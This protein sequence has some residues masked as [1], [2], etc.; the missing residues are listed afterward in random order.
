M[1]YNVRVAIYL[2]TGG[3]I[4]VHLARAINSRLTFFFIFLLQVQTH[5]AN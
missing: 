2:L 1:P 5:P 3:I 4:E